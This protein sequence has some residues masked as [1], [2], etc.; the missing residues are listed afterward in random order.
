MT[1][2]HVIRARV[3]PEEEEALRKE[4]ERHRMTLSDYI[5]NAPAA[6]AAFWELEI[7][8]LEGK[9]LAEAIREIKADHPGLGR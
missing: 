7:K 1:E 8:L 6:Y 4:A 5:R 9:S 2:Y 3:T